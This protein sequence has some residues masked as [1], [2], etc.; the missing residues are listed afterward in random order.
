MKTRNH[1]RGLALGLLAGVLLAAGLAAADPQTDKLAAIA[2]LLRQGDSAA[3]QTL[4][5][6]A[7]TEP[8]LLVRE[9]AILALTQIGGAESIPALVEIGTA[10]PSPAVRRAAFNAVYELRQRFPMSDPP[11]VTFKAVSPLAT[12][13]DMTFE[14][15]VVSPVDRPHAR[16]QLAGSRALRPVREAGSPIPGYQG[17]LKAG[18]AVKVRATYRAEQDALAELRATVR[19][20]LNAVDATTYTTPLY[21]DLKEGS[22]TASPTPPQGTGKAARRAT[23]D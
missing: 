10:P 17:P 8:D 16:I 14:A 11:Q 7:Q 3:S 20:R 1:K 6:M 2:N 5:G 12:G 19:V 4:R 21:L 23:A 22:G 9:H 13:K 15:T 18:Q